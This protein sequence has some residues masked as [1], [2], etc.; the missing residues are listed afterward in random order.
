MDYLS[1]I[2]LTGSSNVNNK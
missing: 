2:L 1:M